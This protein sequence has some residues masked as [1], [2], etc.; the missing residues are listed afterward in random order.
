MEI[1]VSSRGQM[2]I[3]RS[4]RRKYEIERGTILNVVDE[5]DGI[6]LIPPAKL[7]NLCGIWGL[8]LNAVEEELEEDRK[9][10]R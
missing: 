5:E 1:T 10:W 3:P 8:D 7:R 6:K 9:N 2:C 4:I